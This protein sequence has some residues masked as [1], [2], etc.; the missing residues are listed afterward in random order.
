MFGYWLFHFRVIIAFR[1]CIAACVRMYVGQVSGSRGVQSVTGR[2]RLG[3]HRWSNGESEA[4]L[5]D[6]N[7]W[8]GFGLPTIKRQRGNNFCNSFL[9]LIIKIMLFQKKERKKQL[10]WHTSICSY[11]QMDTDFNRNPKNKIS[12]KKQPVLST[13]KQLFHVHLN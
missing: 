12:K 13:T 1:L 2:N 7:N 6:S 4:K 11:V 3:K 8:I 10:W 9:Q 5:L